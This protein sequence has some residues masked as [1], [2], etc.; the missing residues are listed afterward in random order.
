MTATEFA[1]ETARVNSL[2]GDD[3]LLLVAVDDRTDAIWVSNALPITDAE[4]NDVIVGAL[5]PGLRSGDFPAAVVATAE[6]LGAAASGV[7][8][9]PGPTDSPNKTEGPVVVPPDGNPPSGPANGLG[10]LGLVGLVLLALGVVSV[11]V[12]A[13]SRVGAWREAE[14]RDRRTGK[15]ARETNARLIAL[16]DRIR[17]ADQ[18]AGFVEAQFGADEAGPLRAAVASAKAELG[19]AFEVRQRLDDDQPEDPPTR[20]R[21]LNDIL[22]RLGRAGAALDAQAKRID[23]LRTLE[24]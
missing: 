4:I 7:P 22:E 18:E 15:L 16:D 21:M 8:V 1:D 2:G 19:G 20:E 9:E 5:E 12:W 17:A 10:L 3:A 24:R 6:A 23:E 11:V 13:A 14:E